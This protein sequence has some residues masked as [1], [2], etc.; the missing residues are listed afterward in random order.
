M[1]L[2]ALT[3][4]PLIQ[5][6]LSGDQPITRFPAIRPASPYKRIS[7]NMVN[8]PFTAPALR[9]AQ[10]LGAFY[11]TVLPAELLLETCFSDQLRATRTNGVGYELQG[12]QRGMIVERLR[13]IADYI[14]RYDSAFPN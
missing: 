3:W 11:V 1:D 7:T 6:L 4:I 14:D 12:T 13:A 8:F 5:M 9:V 2:S 10:P